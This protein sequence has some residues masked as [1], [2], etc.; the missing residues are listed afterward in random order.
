MA[1]I[2]IVD[3]LSANR[4]FLVTLLRHHGHQ[5]LEASDGSEG[6]TAVHTGHPDLVI[7]DVLMPVMDGYEFARQLRLDPTTSATPVAFYTAHYGAREARALA[8]SIAVSDVLTKPATSAEVLKVVGRLLSG[9]PEA[10][11]P[12]DAPRLTAEFDREHLRLLTDKLSENTD[13]LKRS[14]A[15]LR[16]LINIGLEFASERDTGRLLQ[17]VGGAVR[18][19]FGA[20]YVT[21][22]IL[23]RHDRTVRR[24]VTSG[25]GAADWL[26]I[27]DSISGMLRTVVVDRRTW[28]GDN[29]GGDPARL[30]LPPL[31]P[32]IQAF[33]AVPIASSSHVYG[34][35]CLVGNE[36]KTFAEDDEH[37][38]LALAGHV[39]RTYELEHEILERQQA[40][41]ALR[42]ERDMAQR[43]LDTA[44]VILLALDL[45]ARITLIN[46]KGCD[47]LGWSECELIGRDWI[48]TCLPDRMREAS[49]QRFHGLVGGGL[50]LGEN[51]VLTKSGEER[52]IEWRNTVQRDDRGRVIG[53]FSSGADITERKHAVEALRTGEERMR[54]ALK[55]AEV[56]IWDMNY[57]TG[58][59]QWSETMESQ[60]GLQP[61]TFG[62][63]FEAF[64]ERIHPDDRESVL[65]TIGKATTSG[66][67][68][69]V[70]HRAVWPDGTVRWLSGAGRVLLDEHG[71]ALRS[72]GIS[73]DDTERRTL[74]ERY[75]QSQKMESVGRLAGGVAHDFNN[76]LT[77]ILGY[78]ELLVEDLSPDDPRQSEIAE[79][80]KA[81]ERAG[82][83]TRQLLAFSRKQI[84]EPT[85]FDLNLLL[86]DLQSM[87]E[88]LIAE[89]IRIVLRLGPEPALVKADRGQVEQVVM[90]L[91]VNARDAMPEGG[92]LTIETANVELD[93]H[94]ATMH[95][96]VTPGSYVR[97]T[98][99][100][101]G[102]G[103]TPQVQARLFEPFFT[104]KEPGKGTGLGMATVY[105]IVTRCGGS[106]GVDSEVGKGTSFTMHFPKSEAVE[107]LVGAPAQVGG[108][109]VGTET[110][111]VVEGEDELR[112]LARRLLHWQ[113]YTVL[114]A[115]NAD[116]AVR[117]FTGNP[118]IDVLIT[119]A[120]MPG[121]GGPE[122]TSR[123]V[124]QRPAL[125]VIYMSGYTEDTIVQHGVVKPG[126]AFLNKPFTSATLGRKVRQVLEQ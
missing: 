34:W 64:L 39:G 105:G 47:L 17:R 1:T 74:E 50:P 124:E 98:M 5:V 109:L 6:L 89:D 73:L 71:E 58:V 8:R 82:G 62:G 126:V 94:S 4:E 48:D 23:D 44:E 43:Y 81:G 95:L 87:L 88:R 53:T 49:R 15:R 22:G 79:I 27:G 110:V 76:L 96:A 10:V 38:V 61:G 21:L 84:I 77:V 57:T 80:Q 83:L 100:D 31:H 104:T 37:L 125:K 85:Q 25:P 3:D 92:T 16:A 119:D 33:L 42:H 114:V 30:R 19:L 14:N 108:P 12:A 113:G 59:L 107:T 60:Y 106:V 52:L 41:S 66:A 69:S 122:L 121:A 9:E 11:A 40:E 20:T 24:L 118:S 56:G 51:L 90:N 91:A 78:C 120:V 123:L 13:D 35:I 28:R 36:G 32:E 72:V 97:L 29:P 55:S 18:D 112:E 70:V 26:K 68:F 2:L 99:T 101:T 93:E 65:A 7:T 117:L 75:R 116:E 46:R 102:T 54:F 67:D 111:L 86:F 115:A 45:D 63:T 103:M